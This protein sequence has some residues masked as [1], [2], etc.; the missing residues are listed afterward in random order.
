DKIEQIVF[1]NSERISWMKPFDG[2]SKIINYTLRIRY[3]QDLLW[4][5]ETI[6]TIDND[7]IT[8]YS[9]ENIYSI[10]SIS[11]IIQAVNKIGSSL[12]SQPFY[13]QTNI[14][15]LHIAPYNLKAVNIS[16]KSA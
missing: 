10:C 7:D 8:T 6:I 3:K 2:N 1:D 14:K 13:F 9:F 15:R 11:V 12:P 5:N 16:S 4:S